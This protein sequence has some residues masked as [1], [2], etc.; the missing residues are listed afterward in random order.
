[1]NI[2]V[3]IVV[4]T[5]SLVAGEITKILPI[6]NKFI[7]LQNLIIALIS[8]IICIVFEVENMEILESIVTCVFASMS[9]GGI[10][11]IKKIS[12]KS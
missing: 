8:S 11:D 1:M 5:I 6:Q 2:T 4:L 9:A 7:P 10:A 3:S 12:Q